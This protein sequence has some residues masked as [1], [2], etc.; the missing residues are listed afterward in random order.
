MSFSI[1]PWQDNHCVPIHVPANRCIPKLESKGPIG[2]QLCA[3]GHGD[4][5]TILYIHSDTNVTVRCCQGA[6]DWLPAL[7]AGMGT[8]SA[9]HPG[10]CSSPT[11]AVSSSRA[12]PRMK[13]LLFA[14]FLACGKCPGFTRPG[15]DLVCVAKKTYKP[16]VFVHNSGFCLNFAVSL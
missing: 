10:C 8:A 11:V 1:S 16:G 5:F 12:S 7:G 14:V 4:T 2:H 9:L 15:W 13:N 3:L 6:P